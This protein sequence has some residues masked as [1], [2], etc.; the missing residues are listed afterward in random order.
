MPLSRVLKLMTKN[1]KKKVGGDHAQGSFLL[2]GFSF[3][4][5]PVCF[6]RGLRQAFDTLLDL[7]VGFHKGTASHILQVSSLVPLPT[8]RA[9]LT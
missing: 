6:T 9:I 3:E 1:A 5:S 8:G 2:G 4:A 7:P